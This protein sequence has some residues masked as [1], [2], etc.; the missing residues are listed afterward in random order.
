MHDDFQFALEYH[1][2][3]EAKAARFLEHHLYS[4]EPADSALPEGA[5]ES[6]LGAIDLVED[7]ESEESRPIVD[8]D[9]DDGA[10][11]PLS[12]DREASKFSFMSMDVEP[13]ATLAPSDSLSHEDSLITVF[14][15]EGAKRVGSEL[16]Q[17]SDRPN[18]AQEAD[19]LVAAASPDQSNAEL[20]HVEPGSASRFDSIRGTPGRSRILEGVSV[21]KKHFADVVRDVTVVALH[22]Y[23]LEA[24]DTRPESA[25]DEHFVDANDQTGWDFDAPSGDVRPEQAP[26]WIE[27]DAAVRHYPRERTDRADWTDEASDIPL[28]PAEPRAQKGGAGN[29]ADMWAAADH[30]LHAE[31]AADEID[32]LPTDWT[33]KLLPGKGSV[34]TDAAVS[35]E[36]FGKQGKSGVIDL[37]RSQ[38]RLNGKAETV[39]FRTVPVGELLRI[40]IGHDNSGRSPAW[41][42]HELTLTRD[43]DERRWHFKVAQHFD[44]KKGDKK[45]WRDFVPDS[46]SSSAKA[47]PFK[48]AASPSVPP[49]AVPPSHALGFYGTEVSAID[50]VDTPPRRPRLDAPDR[51]RMAS[52]VSPQD[53]D[54]LVAAEAATAHADAV[55]LQ[56]AQRLG[57][58]YVTGEEGTRDWMAPPEDRAVQARVGSPEP[59]RDAVQA[60]LSSGAAPGLDQRFPWAT[61]AVIEDALARA[62]L[63]LRASL[64]SLH[65]DTKRSI[66]PWS[67]CSGDD[68]DL[69]EANI[70]EH[71]LGTIGNW[72]VETILEMYRRFPMVSP[73]RLNSALTQSDGQ[74][75]EVGSAALLRRFAPARARG[76]LRIV[77]PHIAAL[78]QAISSVEARLVPQLG[79]WPSSA[80]STLLRR[81]RTVPPAALA[82]ALTEA[83]GSIEHCT[84]KLM[85]Q[86]SEPHPQRFVLTGLGR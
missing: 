78:W 46:V 54:S 47:T 27:D 74:I 3:D 34:G 36:L 17:L 61:A 81:F 39:N 45:I 85:E 40:G 62:G 15:F 67:D 19:Q 83:D 55:K 68:P 71:Q 29:F 7:E 37:P 26:D 33:L 44:K 12:D 64:P 80:R 5:M 79:A 51:Q 23:A 8:A 28:A 58:T 76:R 73:E 43:A 56:E 72:P 18:T 66:V 22:E 35:I 84:D 13:A 42:L 11:G 2:G 9:G 10:A 25:L 24:Q 49:P 14:E 69:S 50:M 70:L 6:I 16:D 65:A 1:K 21:T 82:Q 31:L 57:E 59:G 77:G 4:G 86:R 75:D 52:P 53:L 30:E 32:E 41:Y 38:N 63:A 20:G 60:P 48:P